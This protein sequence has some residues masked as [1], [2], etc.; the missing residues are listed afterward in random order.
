MVIGIKRNDVVC[1]GRL[2]KDRKIKLLV[3]GGNDQDMP[4][5]FSIPQID[6]DGQERSVH[7]MQDGALPHYLIDVRDFLNNRFPG[8]WTGRGAPIAWPPRSPD[9]TPLD[10]FFFGGR[11]IYSSNSNGMGYANASPISIT[12]NQIFNCGGKRDKEEQDGVRDKPSFEVF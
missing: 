5:N 2:A 11:K 7:F 9:L 4:E 6:E 3:L 10:F 1:V 12:L 8:K